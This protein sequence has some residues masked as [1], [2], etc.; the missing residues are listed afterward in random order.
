MSLGRGGVVSRAVA[1][2]AAPASRA[3]GSRPRFCS[4]PVVAVTACWAPDVCSRTGS[5]R[6]EIGPKGAAISILERT[7]LG[8]GQPALSL[9]R[10]SRSRER[11]R[12]QRQSKPLGERLEQRRHRTRDSG[13]AIARV[14]SP[15]PPYHD[16]PSGSLSRGAPLWRGNLPD[17]PP[18]LQPADAIP[19]SSSRASSCL[20]RPVTP[21]VAGS[22]PV[23][24]QV[25][26][27]PLHRKE[28]RRLWL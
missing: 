22:S 9:A 23:A 26:P 24:P 3:R 8:G 4:A 16:H 28:Q 19:R 10:Q 21:E 17:A 13:F 7:S 11:R 14:S 27:E 12:A 6:V 25:H 20:T 1:A 15:P 2:E 5:E 18:G